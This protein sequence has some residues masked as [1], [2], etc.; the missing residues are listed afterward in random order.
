M[1][2]R[3]RA[4]TRLLIATALLPAMFAEA[5][6]SSDI[7]NPLSDVTINADGST[8]DSHP[9]A[10]T[11]ADGATWIA[12]HAYRDGK[13]RVLLRRVDS[14]GELG[15][16]HTASQDT[17]SQDTG[18]QDGSA[19]GP[20]VVVHL[21]PGSV[22]VVWSAKKRGRWRVV[23]RHRQA[24][25]WR[26][27]VTLSGEQSDAIQPTAAR[28]S[29]GKMVV[30]WSDCRDRR[31]RVRSR[32]LEGGT[33]RDSIAISSNAANAFRPVLA[34]DD[35]GKTWTIW[36]RYDGRR[37]SVAGRQTGP[38]LDS[39][40]QISPKD[41]HC[42]TPTALATRQ[43]LCVAWLQKDDV[44]GGPGVIS[45]WHTLHAAIRREGQWK[46]IRDKSGNSTAAEL[47]QGLVAQIEPR[48]VATGGYLGRRTAPMLIERRDAV[49]LLWER[50]TNH[51]G[52]TPNVV[53][54]L[55]GRPC[56]NGRWQSPALLHSGRVDYHLPHPSHA[57]DDKLVLL[58]SQLPR[59]N[60]R[61]YHRLI[62]D[63]SKTRPFKQEAWTGWRKVELP[64]QSELTERR[65]IRQGDKTLQ[66]YWADLHCHSA[67]TCDAE[68]EHD[69]LTCYARDR[70]RLD[71]VALT[72]ND[73]LYDAPLTEYEYELSAF[74]AG[75][76]SRPGSFLTLPGY[77][78]TSRVPGVRT[79]KFS[80]R[81][82]WTAPYQ[83]RSYPNHRTVIYPPSG[84]PVVRFPEV[85]NEIATLNEAVDKAGGITLTQHDAFLPSGH[86]VEV[87]MEL[88]SGW[89]NYIARVPNLFHGPLDRGARLGF[90]NGDTHRRAPGLSGALT[91]I[92]AE[93]LTAKS[94]LDA[95]RDRRCYATNG[96]RIFVATHA[97]DS[98]MGQDVMANAGAV[99][100]KLHAIGTRPLVSMTLIRDGKEI[101]TVKADGEREIRIEHRDVGLKSGVHWYY[102]R[103]SQS[104]AAAEL[105][106]NL[107]AA[108]G[109]LAWSTPHWVIVK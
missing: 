105:P 41:R 45:Q 1:Q 18:S 37:Y 93:D 15:P 58:G 107:M 39:I 46:M 14:A 65:S 23:A 76:Y 97:N 50:K 61:V 43:G 49:W 22:W 9:S 66:L 6:D 36:D 32:H 90:V 69:E 54:D 95:L 12:W 10:T 89:R 71:V 5:D 101:R 68:G 53:G 55:I 75:V 80:D 51:R 8:Y 24:G 82:N 52:S 16:T 7:D 48:A 21:A 94:I 27:T 34:V 102:W 91:G 77:E 28:I 100:L 20:P 109:H 47:T 70:A 3:S 79:A 83:N 64:I 106:G 57:A 4:V 40:E 13:D 38:T 31:F 96:A 84:G 81:G 42:L 17:G 99:T 108:H 74:F 30:A 73:F 92:Y 85:A 60:R 88:T 62:A 67:L 25:E 35:S 19:H 29:S 87:G 56:I 59:N 11:A 33:W 104:R 2:P 103:V 98:L 78:W 44:I 72:N 26:P 63:M 86:P